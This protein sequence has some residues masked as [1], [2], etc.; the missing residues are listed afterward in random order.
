MEAIAADLE[1]KVAFSTRQQEEAEKM[2]EA[3][4]QALVGPVSGSFVRFSR[5]RFLEAFFHVQQINFGPRIS[6]VSFLLL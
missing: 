4:D 6:L 1:A 3:L 2:R 5:R